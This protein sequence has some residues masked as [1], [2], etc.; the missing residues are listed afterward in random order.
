MKGIFDQTITGTISFFSDNETMLDLALAGI[1][2]TL[3]T[4][5]MAYNAGI[6]TSEEKDNVFCTEFDTEH[7]RVKSYGKN[8]RRIEEDRIAAEK[9]AEDYSG[10][11]E[12]I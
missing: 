7:R 9:I 3:R 5:D 12:A 6:A 1:R 10:Y 2:E 11:D 4:Y 8:P